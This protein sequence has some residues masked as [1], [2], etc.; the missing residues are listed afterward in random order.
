[1]M[2]LTGANRSIFSSTFGYQFLASDSKYFLTT[3]PTTLTA[4]SG[5][6][7]SQ[8]LMATKS[9][10]QPGYYVFPVQKLA[11]GIGYVNSLPYV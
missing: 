5:D 4:N 6:A 10:L 7:A 2:Q 9:N 8:F 3:Y 11:G 1:M